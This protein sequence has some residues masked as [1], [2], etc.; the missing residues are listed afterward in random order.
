MGNKTAPDMINAQIRRAKVLR[1]RQ[2]GYTYKEI[3]DKVAEEVGLDVLPKQWGDRYAHKDVVAELERLRKETL[4]EVADLRDITLQRYDT[5]LSAIQSK[6]ADGDPR[7]IDTALKIEADRR[8][9][10]GLD[11]PTQSKLDIDLDANVRYSVDSKQYTRA[12]E[13]F[14]D[15]L[16]SLLPTKTD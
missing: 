4:E 5:M 11:A 13:T 1:L 9:L 15:A 2:Q 7:A 10:L 3:A 6:V 12:L 8:K 14:V 16:R